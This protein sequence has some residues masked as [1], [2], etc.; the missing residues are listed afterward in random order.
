MATTTGMATRAGMASMGRAAKSASMGAAWMCVW[1][2]WRRE[3]R[4]FFRRPSRIAGALGQPLIFWAVIGSGM[5]ETFSLPGIDASVSYSEYFFPGVVAMIL[6]FA[7]IFSSVG[8][9]EDRKEGFLRSVLV[10]PA[11]R[12]SVVLGK[13]LGSTSIALLQACLF[14]ALAPLAGFSWGSIHV[15]ALF[16]A[17]F[18]SAFGLSAVGFAVAW[19][20]NHLQAFHA[21]QMTL[22]VPL[23]VISGA[24]FPAVGRAGW[25]WA[26]HLNPVAHGVMA[27]RHA[28]YGGVS[29]A[30]WDLSFSY[31]ESSLV[32]VGFAALALGM[33]WRVCE[34]YR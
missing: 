30:V 13:C 28:F 9:I 5:T 19:R 15:P 17:A 23:W 3:I 10:G 1:A 12:L 8:L 7:S 16:A 2:L 31:L 11:P 14:M 32:L 34:R 4:R 20:L 18:L 25:E 6:V 27:M 21:I 26:M 22:L 33:A 24:M 29:P